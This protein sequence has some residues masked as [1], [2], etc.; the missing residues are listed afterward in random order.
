ML[1]VDATETKIDRQYWVKLKYTEVFN[2]TMERPFY[3]P[4]FPR[5][6]EAV[7]IPFPNLIDAPD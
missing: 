3:I 4:L 1:Q 7:E 6:L 2:R 5:A